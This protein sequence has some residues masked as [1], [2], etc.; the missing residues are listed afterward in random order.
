MGAQRSSPTPTPSSYQRTPTRTVPVRGLDIVY[1]S[2]ARTT[3][4][5]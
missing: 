1:R 4:Y 3:A 5:R 2:S